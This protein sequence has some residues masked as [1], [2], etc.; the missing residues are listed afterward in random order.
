VD[1]P[2]DHA[3]DRRPGPDDPDPGPHDRTI[4]KLMRTTRYLVQ[5][6]GRD[7][8]PEEIAERMELP[9]DKVPGKPITSALRSRP[10]SSSRSSPS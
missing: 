9:L 3:R 8:I 6:L 1:P 5:E 4:N 10:T 7:P 2:G